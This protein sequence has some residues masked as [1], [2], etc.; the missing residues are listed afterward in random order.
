[1][2]L[3][4]AALTTTEPTLV[5]AK[6][7][8]TRTQRTGRTAVAPASPARLAERLGALGP[9]RR[10]PALADF[11]REQVAAV[12]GFAD[13]SAIDPSRQLQDLGFDSLTAVEF[14]NRL[15]GAA[16]M[17]LPVTLIFDYP[18]PDALTDHL[19]ERL[20]P[21][22]AAGSPAGAHGAPAQSDA[23]VRALLTSLPIARLRDAG[24]V[25]ALFKL[26]SDPNGEPAAEA[27]EKAE[28]IDAMDFDDL[29]QLAMEGGD[30]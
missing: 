25:E 17:R 23:E 16:D 7:A 6:F 18:T 22:A 12:L 21:E 11:V 19:M 20:F 5:T 4:D 24:L 3:L 8:K 10:R 28:A 26:A 27:K 14:R 15:N 9:A 1:L 13:A 30:S 29:I 2:A